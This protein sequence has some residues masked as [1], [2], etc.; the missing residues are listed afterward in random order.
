MA[1]TMTM[2]MAMATMMAM[3]MAM[4]TA[5]ATAK[6]KAKAT[7][8]A[9]ATATATAG[10]WTVRGGWRARRR[11][12]RRESGHPSGSG[13]VRCGQ[14]LGRGPLGSAVPPSSVAASGG[15]SLLVAGS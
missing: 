4:A 3:A 14:R 12:W 9:T 7:A 8:K 5:T 10:P 6:A 11:A 13:H 1:M 2:T 15:E